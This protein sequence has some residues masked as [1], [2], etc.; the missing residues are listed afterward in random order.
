MLEYAIDR[1]EEQTKA[2]LSLFTFLAFF[3]ICHVRAVQNFPIHCFKALLTLQTL[4][5]LINNQR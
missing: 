4:C 1:T 2:F 3:G 5:S